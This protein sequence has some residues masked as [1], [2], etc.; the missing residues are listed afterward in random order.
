M[1][2]DD[3]AALRHALAEILRDSGYIVLEAASSQE[4]LTIARNY[5][6]AIELLVADVVMPGLRGPG[7]HQRVQA[8]QKR[9]QV[10]FMSGYAEGL[11]GHSASSGALFLQ[12]PFRLA[13][14]LEALR[15]LQSRN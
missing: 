6:G 14:L 10:L 13:S 8:F 5:P 12:E 2:V 7:L 4:A 3:E 1:L 15:T 11:S 9:I